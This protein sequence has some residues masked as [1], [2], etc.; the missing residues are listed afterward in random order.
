MFS[1][2]CRA[3]ARQHTILDNAYET[4]LPPGRRIYVRESRSLS[5]G[6]DIAFPGEDAVGKTRR[7]FEKHIDIRPHLHL[8]SMRKCISNIYLR[9]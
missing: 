4:G 9:G 3:P 6:R 2:C 5:F 7:I 8:I 1:N